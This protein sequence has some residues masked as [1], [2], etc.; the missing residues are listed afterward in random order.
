MKT[1]CSVQL[2]ETHTHWK[3]SITCARYRR[4]LISQSAL[5]P[6]YPRCLGYVVIPRQEHLW[7]LFARHT[8]MSLIL[9]YLV[10]SQVSTVVRVYS[11]L[12]YTSDAADE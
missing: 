3:V 1:L 10:Y 2:A 12:L 4:V 11:C 8:T 5:L 7:G 6:M 9:L